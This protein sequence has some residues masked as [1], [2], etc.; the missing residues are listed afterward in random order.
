MTKHLLQCPH[1]HGQPTKQKNLQKP[2]PE[3]IFELKEIQGSTAMTYRASQYDTEKSMHSPQFPEH[4][5][6]VYHTTIGL[7]GLA[8]NDW[9]QINRVG[10]T[11]SGSDDENDGMNGGFDHAN[12][13]CKSQQEVDD[14]ENPKESSDK[15]EEQ[16]EGMYLFDDIVL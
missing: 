1:H 8:Q 2:Q 3:V 9:G 12:Q 4:D 11:A 5:N 16:L 14:D 13:N 7:L 10:A 15:E 6:A